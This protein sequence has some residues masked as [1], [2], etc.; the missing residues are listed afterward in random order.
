MKRKWLSYLLLFIALASPAFSAAAE[1][2][3]LKVLLAAVAANP[4]EPNTHFNLG[5]EYYNRGQ[6]E[7]A[8]PELEKASKMNSSDRRQRNSS[9]SPGDTWPTSKAISTGPSKVS[10]RR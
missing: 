9:I 3:K 2:V 8:L 5:V 4:G 7:L 6:Y 1:D 10:R